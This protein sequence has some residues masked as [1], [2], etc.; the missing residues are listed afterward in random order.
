MRVECAISPDADDLFMLRGLMLGR[1]DPRGHE[2]VIRT[3]DTHALNMGADADPALLPAVSAVSVAWYP[4]LADRWQLLP[5]GGSVGRGYGPVL[6]APPVDGAPP[7][8]AALRGRRIAVPGTS[9]TA[10]T[11]LRLMLDEFVPVVVPIVP[12]ERVFEA[13][14]A[15]EV[16]AAL[17]IHEGRLTYGDHGLVLIADTGAWWQAA[18]DA[19]LPLGATVI[20]RDLGPERIAEISAA[21]RD[22]IADGLADRDAAIAWLLQRGGPLQTA[23]AVD[24]YLSLY[25]NEDSLEYGEDGRRGVEELL[26]RGVAAG[27][28]PAHP[29]VDWAP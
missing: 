16:D 22:S 23:A 15:G 13:L 6:V 3:A 2:F 28:L 10:Y 18:V 1:V 5:H 25:A 20:R 7:T 21:L 19:P 27:L 24:A 12:P 4:R 29:P 26:R 14:A 17:L 11:V 8:L 9:T